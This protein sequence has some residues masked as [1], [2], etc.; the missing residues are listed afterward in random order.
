[1]TS[2]TQSN[3]SDLLLEKAID[4]KIRIDIAELEM[5]IQRI[6]NRLIYDRSISPEKKS[7]LIL[8]QQEYE[9]MLAQIRKEVSN[10]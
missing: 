10:A 8:D 9:M 5:N 3:T 4:Q 1:M 2:E 6:Q 7:A